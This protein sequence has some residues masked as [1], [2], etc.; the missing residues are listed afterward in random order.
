[1]NINYSKLYLQRQILSIYSS[2]DKYPFVIFY[3]INKNKMNDLLFLKNEMSKLDSKNYIV[4]T[5]CIKL[6]FSFTNFKFIRSNT[7]LIFLKNINDFIIVLKLLYNV[8]FYYSYNKH[9]SNL[10]KGNILLNF[11][12]EQINSI[13]FLHYIVYKLLFKIVILLLLFIYSFIKF[14]K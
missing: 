8:S 10:T 7:L 3:N 14:I 1:M 5:E 2:M 6:A 11:Y 12:N 13:I 4:S 9:F